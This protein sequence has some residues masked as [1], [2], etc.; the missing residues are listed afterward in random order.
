MCGAFVVNLSWSLYSPESSGEADAA[1]A[2]AAG[3][4]AEG[5]ELYQSGDGKH[6]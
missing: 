2:A 3:E 5:S 4:R 1:A 6:S